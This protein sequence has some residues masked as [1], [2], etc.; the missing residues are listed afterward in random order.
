MDLWTNL[1]R[2]KAAGTDWSIPG[3]LDF[4]QYPLVSQLLAGK[5]LPNG[6]GWELPPHKLL[7]WPEGDILKFLFTAGDEHPKCWGT[8]SGLAEG[9]LGIEKALTDGDYD[10]RKPRPSNNGLQFHRK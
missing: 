2:T 9:I 6:G 4:D 1:K 5:A 7:L 10:W 3:G 8:S